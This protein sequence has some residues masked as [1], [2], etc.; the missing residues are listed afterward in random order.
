MNLNKEEKAILDCALA[1]EAARVRRA[2]NAEKNPQIREILG[3]Q[4]QAILVLQGR[5]SAEVVK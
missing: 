1:T 5:V 3:M 4:L 2:G